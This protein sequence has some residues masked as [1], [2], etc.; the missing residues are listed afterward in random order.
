MAYATL[1][2]RTMK[3]ITDP[4]PHL[5]RDAF[6]IRKAGFLQGS[7]GMYCGSLDSFTDPL[8]QDPTFTG[9]VFCIRR[10]FKEEPEWG[11]ISEYGLL[12][13]S[14][15]AKGLGYDPYYPAIL[16]ASVQLETVWRRRRD[17]NL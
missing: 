8:L 6:D 11:W 7:D 1:S 5:P 10:T 14:R 9:W 12:S 13:T 17:G 16:H 4:S 2:R 15:A 3:Q